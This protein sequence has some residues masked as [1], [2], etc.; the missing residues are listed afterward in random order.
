MGTW[1]RI[2]TQGP[3]TV[4]GAGEVKTGGPGKFAQGVKPDNKDQ[5]PRPAAPKGTPSGMKKQNGGEE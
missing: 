4:K 5:I 2:G 1:P 3:G